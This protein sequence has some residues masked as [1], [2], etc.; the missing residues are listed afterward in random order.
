MKTLTTLALLIFPF[1]LF[2]QKD[3]VIYFGINGKTSDIKHQR[4]KNV[5]E[6]KSDKNL[7][8]STYEMVGSEW[9]LV[10]TEKINIKNDKKHNVKAD[11]KNFTG[12]FVRKFEPQK[13]GTLQF[14]ELIGTTVKRNGHTHSKYPL[15]FEGEIK[16][17]HANGKLKSV[18]HYKNN[19]LISN[20]NWLETG[21]PYIDNIF[22]SVDTEAEFLLGNSM[23]HHHILNS[24]KKDGVNT[25]NVE[26]NLIVGFVVTAEGKTDGVKIEKSINDEIDKATIRAFESL[27]GGWKPAVLNGKEV[28]YYQKFPLNIRP[29]VQ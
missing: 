27:Q 6:Y 20:K 12:S 9:E 8:V 7:T 19:E 28:N 3:T 24:F 14:V 25:Y 10:N 13:N 2:A 17:A 16:E 21:E 4:T 23:L 15:V 29:R 22:Y 11:G 5:I 18:S 1:F 26:G